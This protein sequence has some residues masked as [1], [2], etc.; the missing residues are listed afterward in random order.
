MKPVLLALALASFAS[1]LD[2][3]KLEPRGYVSDFA[4]ALDPTAQA[5][6]EAYCGD[7][8]RATGAQIAVVL[9]PS[10]EGDTIE[11]AAVRLFEKWGIGK[12]KTDEGALLLFAM[13]DRK[14]RIELGYGLERF[15]SDGAAGGILRSIRPLLRQG[16]LR[17]AILSAVQQLGDRIAQE[18]G[19]TIA[20]RPVRQRGTGGRSGGGG[21][22]GAIV[23]F[24]I[25]M[26]VLGLFGG[27]R[28]GRGGGGGGGN[29]L[30][31]MLLG[32][33]MSGRRGGSGW[34]HGGFGGG[35][36][37]GGFGGGGGGG[38]GGFGGGGSGG[39]GASGGW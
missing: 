6:I 3:S 24:I 11:D 7:V 27:G 38:F 23:G 32:S 25:L 18:K 1:A 34:S 36:G 26:V 37:G 9:V 35:G 13:E 33:L 8:E 10:L 14:N 29:L 15:I 12:A 2:I 5:S 30:A 22:G 31:G 20:G 4:G 19:V 39:G 16:D 17:N 21:I 28:G